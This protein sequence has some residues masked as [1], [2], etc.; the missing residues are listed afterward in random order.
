MEAAAALFSQ[1]YR[2]VTDAGGLEAALR[3]RE[4]GLTE[5]VLE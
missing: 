3:D 2:R 1:P 5:I 4:P